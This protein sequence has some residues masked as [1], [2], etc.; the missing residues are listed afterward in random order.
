MLLL[1]NWRDMKE[2]KA[3]FGALILLVALG[4]TSTWRSSHRIAT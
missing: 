2:R 4:I 1:K 3:Q